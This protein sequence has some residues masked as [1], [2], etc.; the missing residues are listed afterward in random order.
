VAD[1]SPREIQLGIPGPGLPILYANWVRLN[2]GPF[3]LAIDVG[4]VAPDTPQAP[5]VRLVMTWEH[6]KILRH[7]LD[8]IVEQRERNTGE[9]KTPPGI[10]LTSIGDGPEPDEGT[11]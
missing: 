3:D 5:D 8:E 2:P 4:Y 6:A 7:A 9:I 10:V 11:G 1:D